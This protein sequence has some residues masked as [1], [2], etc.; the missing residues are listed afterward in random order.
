LARAIID[1]VE[2]DL[3]NPLTH[4]ASALSHA[5][6][7]PIQARRLEELVKPGS[8]V[9]IVV[10]DPSRWTPVRQALPIILERLH[11]AGIQHDDITITV[12]VGRH[13]SVDTNAMRQRVG[14]EITSKYRCYSPPFNNIF[15]YDDLGQ[16]ANGVYVRIFQP[17]ARASLR[18]LIGSVLP[19]LQAGFGGGYKLILPGTSHQTTLGQL[20]RAGLNNHLD[21]KSLLGES[22]AQNTMRQ[23]I[24]AA[25]A[26]LGP[27]WSVSHLLGSYGDIFRIVAGCPDH[28]QNI[29][30]EEAAQRLQAPMASAVDLV[31]AGNSPWPGDPMQSFKVLLQHRAA[32]LSGG[33]LAGVFWT[34]PDE[35]DRSFPIFALKCIAATGKLGGWHIRR[36]LPLVNGIA[37]RAGSL[38]AFMLH[39][40]CELVVHR[41]VL[42]YSP[43]LHARIG[44]WLGPVQIFSEQRDMW[45]AATTALLRRQTTKAVEELSVRIFPRGGLTYVAEANVITNP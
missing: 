37:R 11:R 3:Q 8:S 2:P 25:A 1:V 5:L 42:V 7:H 6:D 4:Y 21:P 36:L 9:A 22:A 44:Q 18:I 29:L 26:L 20:H 30:A 43:A 38:R 39:W 32:C 28:V 41:T 14:E 19:H 15:A 16:T 12:G 23:S 27:C 45:H 31:I 35:I 34:D 13:L 17:V 33:V 40:A 24:H 10:D